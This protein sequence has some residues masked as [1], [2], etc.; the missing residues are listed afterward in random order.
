MDRECGK[1]SEMP[2]SIVVG[3]NICQVPTTGHALGIRFMYKPRQGWHSAQL[4]L[5]IMVRKAL[6]VL[7]GVPGLG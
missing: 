7:Y 4:G 3:E 1:H 2:T 6:V 5:V